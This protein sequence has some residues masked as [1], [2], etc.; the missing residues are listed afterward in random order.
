MGGEQCSI[1]RKLRSKFMHWPRAP[2]LCKEK[3][4]GYVH[5]AGRK[6]FVS[7]S[8]FSKLSWSSFKRELGN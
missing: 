5:L 8:V 6:Q 2:F 1:R 7:H 3:F 4:C